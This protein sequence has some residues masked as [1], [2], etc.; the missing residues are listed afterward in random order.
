MRFLQRLE[1][2]GDAAE[3]K[4][5]PLEVKHL[6]RQSLEHKL[7]RFRVNLLRVLRRDAVVFE[8]DRRGAAPEADVEASAAHLV[9]HADFFDQP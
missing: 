8:L 5:P 7:H 3:R 9:E 6:V 4:S 2:H 1:F